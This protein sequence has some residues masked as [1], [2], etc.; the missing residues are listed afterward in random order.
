MKDCTTKSL[1]CKDFRGIAISPVVSKIFENCLLAKLGDLFS[2]QNN[3]FGFKEGLGC[4]HAIYTVRRVVEN[5]VNGG[6]QLICAQWI[7]AK[8]SIKLIIMPYS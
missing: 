3:Q 5:F 2:T 7:L 1:N 8:H 6:T 4:N